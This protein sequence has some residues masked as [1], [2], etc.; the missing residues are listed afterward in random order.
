MDTFYFK[1][2]NGQGCSNGMLLAVWFTS[3]IDTTT[4]NLLPWYFFHYSIPI[5]SSLYIALRGIAAYL[6]LKIGFLTSD[7]FK[8][9]LVPDSNSSRCLANYSILHALPPKIKKNYPIGP[10]FNIPSI[11]L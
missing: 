7:L 10:L 5:T 8:I 6:N 4:I 2:L 3:G 9:S 11:Q 1:R